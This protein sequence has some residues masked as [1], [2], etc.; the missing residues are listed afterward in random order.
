MHNHKVETLNKKNAMTDSNNPWAKG[1]KYYPIW[2]EET[3]NKV[4]D[5]SKLL[6]NDD[7]DNSSQATKSKYKVLLLGGVDLSNEGEY[8]TNKQLASYIETIALSSKYKIPLKRGDIQ[9][10]NSPLFSNEIDGKDIY[11]EILEIAKKNFDYNNGTLI[12]YGYSWGG[13]LLM[14]FL[15]F[16][17]QSGIKISLLLTIDAAKGYFSFAVNN[18]VTN[19][20]KFNLNLYQT[21]GSS[22][23]SHG[24]SNEGTGVK[25]IDL[26]GEKTYNNENVIH[27]NIDEYTLLYS[28][29]VILYALKNIY[30]FNNYSETE[31]KQQIH[32]YASQGF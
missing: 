24:G 29:Q 11:K 3:K 22:V 8:G 25:N 5:T 13:Q 6:D 4:L 14:E 27:S 28:A 15:K 16:F 32:T 19:N 18:D 31:I 30:S 1:G 2:I 23:G 7:I 20:V 12:L 10:I 9:I 21:I 26:T 17:K